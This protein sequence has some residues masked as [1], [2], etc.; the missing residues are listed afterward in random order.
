MSNGVISVIFINIIIDS[1]FGGEGAC[2]IK[3]HKITNVNMPEL[4]HKPTTWNKMREWLGELKFL[5]L[6]SFR[7]ISS[8]PLLV[9]PIMILNN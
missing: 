5:F 9:N 7:L 2:L 3:L 1:F 4:P 8:A 6:L